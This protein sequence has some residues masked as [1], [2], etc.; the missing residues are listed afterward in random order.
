MLLDID[1]CLKGRTRSSFWQLRTS[2]Y[3]WVQERC[4]T[5]VA[6]WVDIDGRTLISWT[7]MQRGSIVL[8]LVAH[9]RT[10]IGAY[11]GTDKVM[12]SKQDSL[13]HGNYGC[14]AGKEYHAA[15]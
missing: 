8:K 7:S 12:S 1:P 13:G 14:R 9:P 3:R 4:R 15:V 11:Y 5:R 10:V 6:E 2:R